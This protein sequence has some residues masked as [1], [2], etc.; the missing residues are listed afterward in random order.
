MY[1]CDSEEEEEVKHGEVVCM[2]REE[3]DEGKSETAGE[4][5]L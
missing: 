3:N 1:T 4:E 2:L 5:E